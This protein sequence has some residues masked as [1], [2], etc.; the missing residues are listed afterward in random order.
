MDPT[1][2]IL[3]RGLKGDAWALS[4]LERTAS[5]YVYDGTTPEQPKTCGA[6][7]F[8]NQSLTEVERYESQVSS[9]SSFHQVSQKSNLS[10]HVQLLA[11]MSH[12]A[13]KRCPTSDQKL[14]EA[15]LANAAHYHGSTD[16]AQ[17]LIE[18]NSQ[19][20]KR[21][22][23][24]IAA[25]AFDHSH[26]RVGN[27]YQSSFS[28]P[29]A[30]DS[31]CAIVATNAIAAGPGEFINLVS[32]WIIPSKEKLPPFSVV[33]V[34]YHLA[35]E[36]MG[37]CAP[38]GTRHALKNILF[39]PIMTNV[40]AP[41]LIDAVRESDVGDR[42][43]A[44]F[45]Y[46]KGGNNCH[47]VVA[48]TL[49]AMERWSAAID[50]NLVA[51]QKVFQDSNIN[52]VE[53]ISDV[54][55]SD[56]ELVLSSLAELLETLLKRQD[57]DQ[58]GSDGIAI[59]GKWAHGNIVDKS[60]SSCFHQ[61]EQALATGEKE[62]ENIVTELVSGIGLQRLR[63]AARLAIGDSGIC[64]CL[65]SIARCLTVTS[66]STIRSGRMKGR[67]TGMI[68]LLL[69]AA[70][71]PS[72]LVCG[73]ALESLHT[74]VT[75]SSALAMRLLT[76][77]QGRAIVPPSLVGMN[78]PDDCAVDFDEFQRFRE[79]QLSDV[80][81][82]CYISNRAYYVESC[83][84]AVE[85][86]CAST[87]N[88][89]L[90]YQ[91]EAALFCLSAVA[92]DASKRALL[93]TSTPAAQIAA[94]K[95]CASEQYDRAAMDANA[96][97]EDAKRHNE[98]LERC[99]RA[100]AKVPTVALSNPLALS[101]MCR[102][103]GKYAN[104]LSKTP[105]EGVL[106]ASAALALTSF[107]KAT[108]TFIETADNFNEIVLSPFTEAANAL[109]NILNRSPQHFATP[110]ALL[111]LENGWKS[112][113]STPE[114]MRNIGIDD[115]K[116]LCGGISRVLAV[117]PPEKWSTSLSILANPTIQCLKTVINIVD[118]QILGNGGHENVTEVISRMSEEICVLATILRTFY[119]AILK[120]VKAG[121]VTKDSN[122]PILTVLQNV[123]PFLTHIAQKYS[124]DEHI[125][126]ALGEF[127]LAIVSIE[128]NTNG[129]VLL[130]DTCE[131]A[132]LVMSVVT[133]S[134]KPTGLVP[135]MDFVAGAVSAFGH[136][137]DIDASSIAIG[138][139]ALTV[140][141]KEIQG[142]I[143]HLIYRCFEITQPAL[144]PKCKQEKDQIS[145]E[146]VPAVDAIGELK[147]S[148]AVAGLFSVCISCVQKC[149]IL[150]VTLKGRHCI[151]DDDGIFS[152]SV[153]TAVT[154]IGDKEVNVSRSSMLF[155][156]EVFQLSKKGGD[157]H[158]KT[159]IAGTS[160]I[161]AKVDQL[162]AFVRGGLISTLI[163]GA[164]GIFPREVLDPAANLLY[165]VLRS[166]PSDEAGRSAIAAVQRESF[167]LGDQARNATIITLGKCAQGRAS[168]AL[169]MNLFEDLWQIHQNDDTGGTVAGSD[170]VVQFAEKYGVQTS[171]V[172]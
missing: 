122:D 143:V 18:N 118:G 60:V 6:W 152:R 166:T 119:Y 24:R 33:A 78:T 149:P 94:A 170:M 138:N 116:A 66:Q 7:D 142:I 129:K 41:L 115:K 81:M 140:D 2:D 45:T 32:H 9:P 154:W 22:M 42:V 49:K 130:R 79:Y 160:G 74:L 147:C 148:E 93:L 106:E 76:V 108:S 145:V 43:D 123:W 120:K 146:K 4:F 30:I 164:C 71:H 61:L 162:T 167:V 21:V 97:G 46:C 139:H 51:F 39:V 137:A 132:I 150:F 8:L 141:T 82:A 111:A 11:T 136:V 20:R 104:W 131:M 158:G 36:A 35:S 98:Q 37:K 117:L 52:I 126:F 165:S 19:M 3:D 16:Q 83:A 50:C 47:R 155:L 65:V 151:Q 34:T 70:S 14:V 128:D 67:E 77:L 56:S 10:G 13:A 53:T 40:L 72:I 159:T 172:T 73:I 125:S 110:E 85:E 90:P 55:Y 92:M 153:G 114:A 89:Q 96:I 105:S 113:Y 80:L 107:N 38:C 23:G 44:T 68:E 135:M 64:R 63:F 25:I 12:A 31:L 29:I 169:L 69:K 57:Q 27:S 48:M 62:R 26:H 87:T 54:L 133:Q 156:N 88:P 163:Y 157:S 91:L 100:L 86:F 101:Q 5:I 161:H 171:H 15:C 168:M 99:I 1:L 144:A 121:D 102:F 95:A 17:H 124:S 134:N 103:I 84:S 75:P 58:N 28:N 59:A 109:R 127:L 112:V